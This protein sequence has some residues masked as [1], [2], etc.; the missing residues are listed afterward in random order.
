MTFI[1]SN[2]NGGLFAVQP[3]VAPDGTLTFTPTL[4]AIGSSTVTVQAEDDGGS[5]GAGI[6]R[7][8]PQTFTITII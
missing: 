8:P 3:A 7:S 2:D 4:L 6:D 1:V 5:S